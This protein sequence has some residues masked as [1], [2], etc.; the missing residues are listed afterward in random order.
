[1]QRETSKQAQEQLVSQAFS[2]Q[3]VHFDHIY[4]SNAIAEWMRGRARNEVMR[5]VNKEAHMLELNCGTGMDSTWFAK[6]GI[7]V[8]ATD[9]APGMLSALRHKIDTEHL[10]DK[11]KIKQ[12]SYNDLHEVQQSTFDYIFSNFGGLNCT[13][14]LDNV[15]QHFDRLLKP[16]GY[17]TL[18]IMPKICPWELLMVLKGNFKTA[19][20]RFKKE[21]DAHIEGVRFKCYYY[22]PN[23]VKNALGNK[24]EAVSLKGMC[25]IM[26]PPFIDQFREKHPRAFLWLQKAELIMEKFFPFNRCC[27]HYIITLRKH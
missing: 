20:R 2:N 21:T 1:M 7:N 25:F 9:N 10:A 24:F 19:F 6:Q 16:G 23:Y 18:V 11:I 26:P 4:T 17:C 22:N 12:C 27:D 14:Q 15:L 5:F 8:F 3:S 13:D